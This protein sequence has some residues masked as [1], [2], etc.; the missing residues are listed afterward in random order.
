MADTTSL[1]NSSLA[2]CARRA[3]DLLF[4]LLLL[5]GGSPL[6]LLIGWSIYCTSPGP[7]FYSQ[8]RIGKGGKPFRMYKFRTM[9]E[10]AEHLLTT[11]LERSLEREKEWNT[12]RKLRN[13]PRVTPFGRFLRKTSLDELPQFWNVLLGD[14]SVVGPRAM[15]QA[16][17]QEC[18]DATAEQILSIKPGITGLWQVSGR[19]TLR[20]EERWKL[21]K[22]YVAK[23]SFLFDLWLIVRTLPSVFLGKGL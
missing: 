12:F 17:L 11:L 2:E 14:L 3:F 4:S 23:R 19:H 16:E 15:L 13:D 1:R 10:N 8:L 22:E 7:I 9:Q 6:F 21:E 18:Q 5:I 20:L